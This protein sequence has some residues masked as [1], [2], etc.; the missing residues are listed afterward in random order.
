MGTASVEEQEQ[1][2]GNICTTLHW[3]Q[4][5]VNSYVTTT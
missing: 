4:G 3:L 1:T 5:Y 2:A